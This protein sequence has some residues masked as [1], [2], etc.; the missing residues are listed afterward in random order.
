MR[1]LNVILILYLFV[2]IVSAQYGGYGGF[3]H[4]YGNGFRGNPGIGIRQS[5]ATIGNLYG[6]GPRGYGR[7]FGYYG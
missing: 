4:R 2:A 3:G 6:I 7:S 5:G 1:P